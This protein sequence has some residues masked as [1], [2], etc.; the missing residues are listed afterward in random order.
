MRL[1]IILTIWSL[2]SVQTPSKDGNALV[3][4]GISKECPYFIRQHYG[5]R[6][7]R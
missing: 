7:I 6:H 2:Y 5:D 1:T 3:R 4:W